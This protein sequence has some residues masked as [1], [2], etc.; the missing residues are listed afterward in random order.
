MYLAKLDIRKTFDSVYQEALAGEIAR[1][2]GEAGEA[3]AWVSLLKANRIRIF[4]RGDT[5]EITQSNGV[6]QGSPDSPIAFGRIVARTLD[7]SLQ[8][9]QAE[10]PTQGE[11]PP[12]H[13]GSYTVHVVPPVYQPTT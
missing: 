3:K 6:R 2:V 4:F 8:E 1:D 11:P 13:G 12:E 7:L 5:F 10:R 9:A